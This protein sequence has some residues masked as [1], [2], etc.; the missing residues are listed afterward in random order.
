MK[1]G[2]VLLTPI[3]QADGKIKLRPAL[4]LKKMPLFND[5]L[6]CGIS[7][8][9]HHQVIDFDEV[10]GPSDDDFENSGLLNP[11]LIRLGFLA[12]LSEK[13]AAGKLGSVSYKRHFRLLANLSK[14]L[15]KDKTTI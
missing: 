8:Q 3:P 1:E 12:I 4:A 5:F 10:I 14:Y 2:D 11:S 7:S 13:N 6:V 9:L 15:V